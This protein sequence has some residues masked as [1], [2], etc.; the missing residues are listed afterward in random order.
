MMGRPLYRNVEEIYF[1]LPQKVN[2]KYDMAHLM[3]PPDIGANALALGT[4]A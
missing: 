3:K 4:Q 2:G 1:M